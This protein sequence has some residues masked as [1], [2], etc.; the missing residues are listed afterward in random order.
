MTAFIGRVLARWQHARPSHTAF[1]TPLTALAQP[2]VQLVA[3]KFHFPAS[4]LLTPEAL[5]QLS[6]STTTQPRSLA[7]GHTPQPLSHSELQVRACV[8]TLGPQA[9]PCCIHLAAIRWYA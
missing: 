5:A 4:V 2:L 1:H 7:V 9:H 6:S 3:L 8:L